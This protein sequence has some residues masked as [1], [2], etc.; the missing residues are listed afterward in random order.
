MAQEPLYAAET[1]LLHQLVTDPECRFTWTNHA[2]EQMVARNIVAEDVIQALT[3]GHILFHEIKRDTL[4]RVDGRDLDGRR[5]QVQVA[6][7]DDAIE[8]KI[9]TTF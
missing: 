1:A 9:I 4:Y 8:I 7:N 2:L 3:N 5:L 6:L